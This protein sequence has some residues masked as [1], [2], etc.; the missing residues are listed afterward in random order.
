MAQ[1]SRLHFAHYSEVDGLPDN[2][3]Y[4]LLI[5]HKGFLW[6]GTDY[7][8]CRFDGHLFE[9]F[10]AS[11]GQDLPAGQL[12]QDRNGQIWFTDFRGRLY[13]TQ[14]DSSKVFGLDSLSPSFQMDIPSISFAKNQGIVLSNGQSSLRVYPQ[15]KHCAE[16]SWKAHFVSDFVSPSFSKN[17]EGHYWALGTQLHRLDE[18]LR[19][20]ASYP[21][22]TQF[23]PSQRFMGYANKDGLVLCAKFAQNLYH[24]GAQGHHKIMALKQAAL[25]MERVGAQLYVGT[26]NGLDIYHQSAKGWQWEERLLEGM[27]ISAIAQDSLGQLWVGTLEQGLFRFYSR[28]I[29][30]HRFSPNGDEG[31]TCLLAQNQ[32]LY[33]GSQKSRFFYYQSE[34]FYALD[35]TAK[36]QKAYA[37]L[38]HAKK[39]VI[40]SGRS[41]QVY[42]EQDGLR[43]LED[44][45]YGL[46]FHQ[47]L[48]SM[49]YMVNWSGVG[50]NTKALHMQANCLQERFHLA[51]RFGPY[52]IL[53]KGQK[54]GYLSEEARCS[55][56]ELRWKDQALGSSCLFVHRDR[57]F[58]ADAAQRYLYILDRK[59]NIIKRLSIKGL[60]GRLVAIEPHPR[61]GYLLLTHAE[62]YRLHIGQRANR[63]K[64]WEVLQLGPGAT[65]SK[66]H[67]LSLFNEQLWIAHD[68]GL[69]QVPF[70]QLHRENQG[71]VEVLPK[72]YVVNGLEVSRQKL[73]RL[74]YGNPSVEVHFALLS[75]G[76]SSPPL[77]EYR[78]SHSR[79]SST[80]FTLSPDERRIELSALSP[81]EHLLEIRRAGQGESLFRQHLNMA[82][83]YW[84][85]AWFFVLVFLLLL[86]A[87]Y[88]FYRYRM[89]QLKKQNQVLLERMRMEKELK[90]SNLVSLKSQLNPHF[91]F[92]S[93]NAIQRFILTND[94]LQASHYLGR[95]AELMRKTLMLSNMELI[96]LEEEVEALK[97]YLELESLRL[98]GSLDYDL[99]VEASLSKQSVYLPALLLQPFVENAVKHGLSPKSADRKLWVRFMQEDSH[100]CIEIEDNGIGREKAKGMQDKR[101]HLNFSLS[102]NQKRIQLMNELY[103]GQLSMEIIDQ[104]DEHGKATGTLVRIQLHL[105]E[106]HEEFIG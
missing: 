28:D 36:D 57:L 2:D 38:P 71:T 47:K 58:L 50:R 61:L 24:F 44:K 99:K 87:G 93:L 17:K 33:M 10:P 59:L 83:P 63:Q 101:K 89:S 106:G 74:P 88:L 46:T 42:D 41:L 43:L 12:S 23:N 25:V 39:E 53:G 73:E 78:L 95:F 102:A 86:V 105:L 22:D 40:L 11:N 19:V 8:L 37:V 54:T 80:W 94:R 29:H 3:I 66:A 48:D 9:R 76:S 60:Q 62:L 6:V 5:G 1:S 64:A 103:P 79:E 100:L 85:Q 65:F 14:G 13:Q 56:Q 68:A 51:Q 52:L 77:L 104:K 26:K 70:A 92:N 35:S 34:Q 45:P 4:D 82:Y 96:A 27:S 81:G 20:I 84:M 15:Q 7:G 98:E 90:A 67:A 75:M 69:L 21:L 72:R 97:V 91:M 32:R 16:E 49:Y 31:I 55:F 30:N 18:E